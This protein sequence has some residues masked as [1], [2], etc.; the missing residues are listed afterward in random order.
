MDPKM[1]ADSK[2]RD[3]NLYTDILAA[4]KREIQN[5]ETFWSF[6]GTILSLYL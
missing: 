1:M 3:F 4:P 2:F 5:S 6:A